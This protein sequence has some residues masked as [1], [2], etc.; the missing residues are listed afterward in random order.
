MPFVHKCESKFL[1][2]AVPDRDTGKLKRI[3]VLFER[4]TVILSVMGTEVVFSKTNRG[5]TFTDSRE[6]RKRFDADHIRS[7]LVRMCGEE[8]VSAFRRLQGL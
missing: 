6:P 7:E 3:R 5:Q 2:P 8:G 4:N 1:F